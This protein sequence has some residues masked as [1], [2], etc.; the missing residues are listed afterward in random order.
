MGV[1]MAKWE[2]YLDLVGGGRIIMMKVDDSKETS[3]EIVNKVRGCH[4]IKS[5]TV[6]CEKSEDWNKAYDILL[7]HQKEYLEKLQREQ[8]ER[9]RQ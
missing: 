5:S 4:K 3:K 2:N 8:D 7:V 6:K 9:Y 1:M